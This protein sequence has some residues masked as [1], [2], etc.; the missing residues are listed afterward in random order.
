MTWF[1]GPLSGGS[2]PARYNHTATLVGGTRMFIFG[3]WNGKKYYNDLYYL[4]LEGMAWT[5]CETSGPAPSPRQGHA[6]ILI[7][8]NLVIQGGYCLK[9]NEF[10]T[11]DL[12]VGT[13]L[14]S[15]YLNDIRVLDTDT[16]V[17]SRLRISG[18]PPNARFGHS[19]NV[20]GSDIL[21]FGGWS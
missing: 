2:P 11:A 1:Q 13:P 19:M 4:D 7:G 15:S 14:I 21:M 17:W 5:I 10:K 16:L 12:L 6:A 9:A 8:N 18:A 3:G 20:S